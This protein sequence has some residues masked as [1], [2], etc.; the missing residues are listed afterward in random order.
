M[1]FVNK[2]T[3]NIKSPDGLSRTTEL[4]KHTL[5]IGPNESGLPGGH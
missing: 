1:T 3:T 2:I 4:G 5:L